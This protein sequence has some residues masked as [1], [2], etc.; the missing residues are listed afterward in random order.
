MDLS[1]SANAAQMPGLLL[2]P[3]MHVTVE[4]RGTGKSYDIGF[5]IDRLVRAFPRGVIAIT[6]QTYGQLLTRTLPSSLKVLTQMPYQKDVNFVIGKKPPTW[7]QDSYE[8]LAKFDNVISFSNG[9][10]FVLIS[11]SEKGSGRGA[12]TDFEIVDEALNFS[13][14]ARFNSMVVSLSVTSKSLLKMPAI[15]SPQRFVNDFCF[16]S[17]GS[18]V[19]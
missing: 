9:S 5:L 11:Q 12:N 15:I 3:K 13:T 19:I 18:F 10:R 4:G 14:I 8:Q 16:C 7:Y 2:S 6:E 17:S 1:L